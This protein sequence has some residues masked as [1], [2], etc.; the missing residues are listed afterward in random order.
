MACRLL[1]D[2]M[3]RSLAIITSYMETQT[4]DEAAY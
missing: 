3:H 2:S 4:T 1:S